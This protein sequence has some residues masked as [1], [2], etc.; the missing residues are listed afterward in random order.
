MVIKSQNLSKLLILKI[1]KRRLKWIRIEIQ[2]QKCAA[3]KPQP[4]VSNIE[5]M[6]TDFSYTTKRISSVYNNFG[7]FSANNIRSNERNF[8]ITNATLDKLRFSMN[9]TEIS[10]RMFTQNI[11]KE[12]LQRLEL[13]Q[14]QER[15]YAFNFDQ[16]ISN[17]KNV[18]ISGKRKS[19]ACLKMPMT[20]FRL[21]V[22]RNS[23]HS[24]YQAWLDASC[25]LFIIEISRTILQYLMKGLLTLIMVPIGQNLIPYEQDSH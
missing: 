9:K 4:P 5:Y 23:N 15:N 14:N 2:L 13:G 20:R 11:R 6:R 25:R 12:E 22:K 3:L 7:I 24:A 8:D 17:E 18:L 1:T 16:S 21:S 19:I 10:R